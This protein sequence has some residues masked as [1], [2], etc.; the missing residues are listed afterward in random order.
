[1]LM[2]EF[3]LADLL[4]LTKDGE[5]GKG[6]PSP[7]LEPMMVIRGTDFADARYCDI[8]SIPL[9][10]I[11]R[12]IA[13]RKAL[14]QGDILIETAGGTKDQ[15]TGRTVFLKDKLFRLS[16][17]RFTCASFSRF[18]RVKR[19]L[20][21]PDYL[22][23]FLQ[24]LYRSG[25]MY[26]FHVQHTGVARFQYTQFAKSQK[27]P[28]PSL[29]VQDGITGLLNALDDKI[30]LNRRMNDTLEAMARAIFEDW[31][32][33]FGP[34][35][36]DMGG[37]AP[38][39]APEIWR[40]FPH[41]L[42]DDERPIGWQLV[43]VE[44][45]AEKVAMGPFGSNIKVSTF[46]DDGI[47]VVSGQHLNSTLMEDSEFNFVTVEHA[48]RLRSANVFRGDIVF[49]HAGNIGQVSYIPETSQYPRYVLSQRQFYLRCNKMLVSPTFLVY[50]FRAPE[51][52]HKLLA[53]TSST[54]VPS[55]SRPATNL[56]AIEL[57]LP[58]KDILEAFDT[59]V[60]EN[61]RTIA[62]NSSENNTLAATR[63]LLLPKLMSGGIRLREAEKMVEQVT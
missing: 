44:D 5:W 26:P 61:H 29:A 8:S 39:L 7:D 4:E 10:Y 11:P 20:I 3:I 28:V 34:T 9:R 40:L 35:R 33:Y 62:A 18:L 59:F 12:A 38:Y 42:G 60:L 37:R 51:G 46:V 2:R 55:I 32:V 13:Q 52:Q 25:D 23:W 48:D 41:R 57:C 31:F 53:N 45:I 50:F 14:Q 1:M 6:D 49:T 22:F 58:S 30:D 43:K 47:P 16:E 27:V 21:R 56:K 54:G 17:Y 36:A 15:P 63:D 19:D 24:D